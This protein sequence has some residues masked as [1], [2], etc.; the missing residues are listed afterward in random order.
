MARKELMD[1]PNGVFTLN[2][3]PIGRGQTNRKRSD[4]Q[5]VQFFLHQFYLK[6]PAL[7]AQLPPTKSK[8]GVIK[9]DG[10]YGKQT[11]AGILVFQK[12]VQ[13]RGSRIKVDGIVNVANGVRST[14]GNQF[15]IMFLNLFFM[16]LGD[17]K[18]HHGKLENHPL[19]FSFA[20][21]LA[22]ELFTALVKN[23]F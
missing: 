9:I 23:E 19:V 16:T 7:F 22:G 14:S 15:T 5:L 10:E 20:P 6:N 18:E 8:V 11:E 3:T 17:G 1:P 21:E 2:E 13:K 4:V 12:D